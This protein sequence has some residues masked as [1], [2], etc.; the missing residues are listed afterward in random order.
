[1]S[2]KTIKTLG[3]RVLMRAKLLMCLCTILSFEGG[4]Q[5]VHVVDLTAKQIQ[6]ELQAAF[7]LRN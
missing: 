4:R 5:I 1:V 3:C 7:I 6:L 2:G